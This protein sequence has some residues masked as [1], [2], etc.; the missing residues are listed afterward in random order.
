VELPETAEEAQL[1]ALEPLE[2]GHDGAAFAPGLDVLVVAPG[3]AWADGWLATEVAAFPALGADGVARLQL[4][5]PGDTSAFVAVDTYGSLIGLCRVAEPGT[6]GQEPVLF[7][8]PLGELE[9]ALRAPLSEPL[10]VLTRR[11]Y[12]GTFGSFVAKGRSALEDER[13]VEASELFLLALERAPAEGKTVEEETDVLGLLEKA[14]Q[15]QVGLLRAKSAWRE[16]AAFLGATIDYM[17]SRRDLWIDLAA[18]YLSISE[19]RGAAQAAREARA[20]ERGADADSLL[21]EAYSGL[22]DAQ[23][24]AGDSNAAAQTLLDALAELPRSAAL[25]F[26]LAKVYFT[27]EYYD[28]AAR[29]FQMA[30]ELDPSLRGEAQLYLEKIEDA[31]QRRDAVVIPIPEGST[32]IRSS[33]ML[34]RQGTYEFIVDT[35]A[36]FT[37]I[38]RRMAAE[39]G[40]TDRNGE[41]VSDR[42][43]WVQTANG[44]IQVPVVQL[45]SASLHGFSVESLDVLVLDSLPGYGLL[46]INFLNNFKFTVDAQRREFRLETP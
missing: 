3:K 17:P 24:A 31:L 19:H 40:Y 41:V 30:E 44:P 22:A 9:F 18:A 11:H 23:G 27:W 32:T 34:N 14:V 28:D 36:T 6:G 5:A 46:G 15:R 4:A 39:L 8:D 25:H 16:L 43:V 7:V 45:E 29:M 35:G 2:A 33:M 20:L 12:E 21:Q 10:A 42:R 26:H 13:Y 1:P 37:A 38:T